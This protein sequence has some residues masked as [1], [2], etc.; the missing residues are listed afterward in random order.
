MIRKLVWAALIVFWPSLSTAV[1]VAVDRDQPLNE[2]YGFGASLDER[3]KK[4]LKNVPADSRDEIFNR[5]FGSSGNQAG[6]SVVQIVSDMRSFTDDGNPNTTFQG[7]WH[8]NYGFEKRTKWLGQRAANYSAVTHIIAR[9][10]SPPAWMKDNQH[11]NFGGYL[12]S[13]Y[14]PTY[15]QAYKEWVAMYRSWNIPI[16]WV[17]VANEPDVA[18][19]Y[20]TCLYTPMGLSAVTKYLDDRMNEIDTDIKILA[21]EGGGYS[22]SYDLFMMMDDNAQQRVDYITTHSYKDVEDILADVGLPVFQTE[23][24][25]GYGNSHDMVQAIEMVRDF[26]YPSLSR[27]ESVWLYWLAI[28]SENIEG[29]RGLISVNP[30][31]GRVTYPKRLSALG[32]YARFIKPGSMRV[33]SSSSNSDFKVVASVKSGKATVVILNRNFQYGNTISISGLTGS[34]V[35]CWRTKHNEELRHKGSLEVSSGSVSFWMPRASI[36]TCVEQ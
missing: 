28:V 33:V 3:Q 36:V 7:R 13:K 4:W 16:N 11:L 1:E 18:G 34:R 25:N 23:I 12:K 22:S 32:Q 6:L 26:L 27:G 8:F 30:A 10:H 20:P 2:I 31:D 29:V 17:T 24:Y 14:Y 19:D 5:L 15:A 35:A 21:P 9:M